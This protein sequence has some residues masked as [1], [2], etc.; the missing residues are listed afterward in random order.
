MKRE[1]NKIITFKADDELS[2]QLEEMSYF[3]GMKKSDFIRMCLNNQI[4]EFKE[5]RFKTKCN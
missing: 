2:E 4:H 1:F 5:K 3:Y